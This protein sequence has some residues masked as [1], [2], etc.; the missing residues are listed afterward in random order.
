VLTSVVLG[1]VGTCPVVSGLIGAQKAKVL[2]SIHSAS[3]P[4]PSRLWQH[5]SMMG[6]IP[7]AD[8]VLEC[9]IS[10]LADRF[11]DSDCAFVA[12]SLVRGEGSIT[13]DIDLVVLYPSLP[14]AYR[15]SFIYRGVPVEAFVH[16][17]ETL[18]WFSEQDREAGHPTLIGMLSEGVLIGPRRDAGAAFQQRSRHILAAG[19]PPLGAEAVSR[20]RYAITDKLDDLEA[21]RTRAEV[22]AIGAALHPLLAELVLRGNGHWNGS[23]KW[24]A[25]LLREFDPEIAEAIERAFV[26]LYSGMDV[27]MLVEL[28]DQLLERHG[29]RLFSG[30]RSDAPAE[31]RSSGD[32]AAT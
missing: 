23:G 19:P 2:K 4:E 26:I 17:P 11:P 14:Q 13:S 32:P 7:T 22:I 30:Y 5:G 15:K 9:S 6:Q 8:E 21:R 16:D 3:T 31:W 20:L 18:L 24:N 12:G 28:A 10:L 25:R 29:G 27:R 1:K